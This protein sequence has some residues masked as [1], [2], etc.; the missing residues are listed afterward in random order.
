VTGKRK[1]AIYSDKSVKKMVVY[2]VSSTEMFLKS[3]FLIP[4]TNR[5]QLEVDWV[6]SC[7]STWIEARNGLDAFSVLGRS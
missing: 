1:L 5:I 7:I 4:N 2:M 3:C 6:V